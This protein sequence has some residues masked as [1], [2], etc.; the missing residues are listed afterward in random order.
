LFLSEAEIALAL[1]P[2]APAI[3]GFF[4]WLLAL[5]GEWEQGQAILV[6]GISLNP[7][8]PGWFHM[9]PYMYF[10]QQGNY[11]KACG[12]ALE[13]KMPQLFWDPLMRAAAL[14][15]LGKAPE[16]AQAVAELLQ[17]RPDFSGAG[18]FL[19]SCYVKFPDL[20]EDLLDGLRLAGLT[21]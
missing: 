10:Y 9:A 14:G 18:R 7:H 21:I 3:I 4:G 19:I 1:N 20:V 15:Q 13:F 6:K 12:E 8:Y 5:Y 11:W 16:A 17:V 2:N